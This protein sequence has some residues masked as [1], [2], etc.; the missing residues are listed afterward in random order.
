M[1]KPN[2]NVLLVL[3][4]VVAT[5]YG[6]TKLKIEQN[7]EKSSCSN[8]VTLAGNT[9][10]NCSSLTPE[11]K[12]LLDRIPVFLNR[13]L[14]NQG[15][16]KVISD[17]LD[18]ILEALSR[19]NQAPVP[20]V[21]NYAPG[22]FATSGG[23]LV[24][25]QINNFRDPLPQI[26]VTSSEPIAAQPRPV[27]PPQFG[28]SQLSTDP[29]INRPGASVMITVKGVFRNP[30]FVADCDVPCSFERLWVVGDRGMTSDS[31]DSEPLSK[32]DNTGAG[33]AYNRQLYPGSK[34]QLVFRSLYDQPLTVSNVRAYD[35]NQ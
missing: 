4:L 28:Q 5:A 30:A 2:I 16:P 32:P 9:N 24:N 19:I 1:F 6:Q 27:S 23:T 33:V 34:I 20:P 22:G 12:K 3:S 29:R 7:S 18:E 11:Q 26:D 17:K 15:D 8:I 35:P 13:I 25:P 21:T 31:K 10:I 14:A